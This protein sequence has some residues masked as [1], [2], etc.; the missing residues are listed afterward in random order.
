MTTTPSLATADAADLARTATGL[1]LAEDWCRAHG[2]TQKQTDEIVQIQQ[3]KAILDLEY[4]LM[5]G[6]LIKD[7]R[8]TLDNGL[9][10]K[11]CKEVLGLS[12]DTVR[13]YEAIYDIKQKV[14][15]LNQASV[16]FLSV[17][18]LAAMEFSRQSHEME[19]EAQRALI[20]HTLEEQ[21][22]VT[23]KEIK[24]LK[25]ALGREALQAQEDAVKAA[26]EALEAAYEE[27]L[28][29]ADDAQE[30]VTEAI[31]EAIKTLEEERNKLKTDMGKLLKD[32]QEAR[33][34]LP[35]DA[36]TEAVVNNVMN[37]IEPGSVTDR[38][39]PSLEYLKTD[40]SGQALVKDARERLMNWMVAN[41]RS[42]LKAIK[43]FDT[44]YEE[45]H[46]EFHNQHLNYQLLWEA[47]DMI[48][49]EIEQKGRWE[50]AFGKDRKK[51]LVD[52]SVELHGFASK[53][54]RLPEFASM[55]GEPFRVK[56]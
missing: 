34:K 9:G 24:D 46:R 25:E 40:P 11:C 35:A 49:P 48:A 17:R 2:L 7:I 26:K 23:E 5:V 55:N 16:E 33:S 19:E 29:A 36:T 30:G 45:M 41:R 28:K 54:K 8:G 15:E 22:K 3:R 53:V 43:E 32:L 38:V 18:A 14:P 27:K 44:I 20:T 47:I 56:E 10:D 12:K 52:F 31:A 13:R 42:L 50:Q 6:K 4:M 37:P 51:M 1:V 21:A 39:T